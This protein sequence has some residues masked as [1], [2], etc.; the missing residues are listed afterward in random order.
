[1]AIAVSVLGSAATCVVV[2]KGVEL[3]EDWKAS[4]DGPSKAKAFIIAHRVPA[5]ST[6]PDSFWQEFEDWTQCAMPSKLIVHYNGVAAKQEAEEVATSSGS[7]RPVADAAKQAAET[8][9]EVVKPE[10]SDGNRR[11]LRRIRKT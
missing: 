3:I 1:M 5:H 9:T 6:I 2:C 10:P 7:K 11:K 4:L 8:N